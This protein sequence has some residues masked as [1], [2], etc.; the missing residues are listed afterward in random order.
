MDRTARVFWLI[1]AIL[2]GA[3]T[4][5]GL[6]AARQVRTTQKATGSLM[7]GDIVQLAKV[8]DG[9]TVLVEKDEGESVVV[10]ILG[11]KAFESKIQHD[12]ASAFGRA[13]EEALARAGEKPLRVLLNNPVKDRRGRTLATI[14]AGDE[15]V[16]LRLVRDGCVLVYTVYP[17][18][19]MPL[20]LSAQ[21]QARSEQKGLWGDREVRERAEA[22]MREWQRQTP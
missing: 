10:R 4:F 6:G 20:Y 13:A 5:Y 21:G 14:F 9:D 16:G 1:I 12:V 17:F 22:I 2:F 15:D 11:I 3:S 19:A 7:S 8:I 18:P